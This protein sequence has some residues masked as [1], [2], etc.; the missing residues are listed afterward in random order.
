MD[1]YDE[2]Q[3]ISPCLGVQRGN[4]CLQEMF[5]IC[6]ILG[7]WR[8]PET[9]WHMSPLGKTHD[10]KWPNPTN[11]GKCVI[12]NSDIIFHTQ[13]TLH[14]SWQ[15]GSSIRHTL[16]YQMSKMPLCPGRRYMRQASWA[17]IGMQMNGQHFSR[18]DGNRSSSHSAIYIGLLW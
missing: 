5:P 9:S 11:T 16:H 10:V 17:A 15:H 1:V 12:Q 6:Q 4:G 2:L 14:H 7:R 18:L 8:N 13:K 3:S